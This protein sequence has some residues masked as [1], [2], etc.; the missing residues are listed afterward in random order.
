G[1][2][3]PEYA[4]GIALRQDL[5]REAGLGQELQS[6]T[7]QAADHTAFLFNFANNNAFVPVSASNDYHY[8]LPSLDLNLLVRPDLKV[9]F[10]ASRTLTK[11]PLNDL[12]PTVSVGGRVNDLTSSTGNP[13]LLPL[14][15]DNFTLG[16]EW[17]YAP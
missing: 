10:D 15:S 3:A 16:A 17:Y 13:K 14:I 12:G 9:R 7:V 4:S 8:L 1:R 5:S 2:Y 11:P 6:L